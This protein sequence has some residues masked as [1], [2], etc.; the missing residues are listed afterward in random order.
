M[1]AAWVRDKKNYGYAHNL[2]YKR[3]LWEDFY[4]SLNLTRRS[5]WVDMF[6][7]H[8]E[9]PYYMWRLEFNKSWSGGV[10]I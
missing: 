6:F 2:F 3:Q 1:V 4:L 10:E 8:P 5:C 9:L 7:V